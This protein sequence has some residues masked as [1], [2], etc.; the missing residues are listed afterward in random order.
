MRIIMAIITLSLSAQVWGADI[1]DTDIK[2]K[3]QMTGVV[4]SFASVSTVQPPHSS[5]K[6][7]L[8]GWTDSRNIHHNGVLF[9]E[10]VSKKNP[11]GKQDIKSDPGNSRN[12]KPCGVKGARTVAGICC[13]DNPTFPFATA[14]IT[15]VVRHY[16]RNECGAVKADGYY[17]KYFAFKA[18][19]LAVNMGTGTAVLLIGR[20][21]KDYGWKG[22]PSTHMT[23]DLVDW[24]NAFTAPQLLA[25]GMESSWRRWC[26]FEH[27]KALALDRYGDLIAKNPK[28]R[29]FWDNWSD[30]AEYDR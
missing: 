27:L 1:V 24:V 26:F 4:A 28:L 23:R 6:E 7:A 25:N 9:F 30:Q 29:V 10:G 22:T 18:T 13:R 8:F 3:L 2:A 12:G 21:A 14:T 20:T 5:C 19:R 15:D 16:E 17:S 11:L